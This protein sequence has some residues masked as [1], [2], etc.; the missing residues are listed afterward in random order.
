MKN[1]IIT[2]VVFISIFGLVIFFWIKDKNDLDNKQT[3]IP[4]FNTPVLSSGKVGELY[5]GELIG[6]L[7]GSKVK[8]EITAQQVPV[9]LSLTDCKQEYN[10]SY[11]SKPNSLITCQLTGY[12]NESG[13]FDS[14]FEINAIGFSGK[15]IG[16]YEISISQ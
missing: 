13:T 3:L 12:P 5:S 16:R 6:S 11:L 10:V 7:I 9:G 8:L 2:T 14:F 1:L 15:T 4:R